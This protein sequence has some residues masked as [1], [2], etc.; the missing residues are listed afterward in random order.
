MLDEQLLQDAISGEDE[1]IVAVLQHYKSSLYRV[2]YSYLRSEQ[3]AL[4]ALQELSY[5]CFRYI[6]TVREPRYFGTWLTK[7]MINICHDMLR[8]RKNELIDCSYAESSYEQ[9]YDIE[10]LEMLDQLDEDARELIYLKYV[11]D[12]SNAVIAK[13]LNI[14]EGTVKSRLYYT[15]RK[16]RSL[17]GE[18]RM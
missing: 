6:H 12:Q 10:W 4:E 1:A 2:A 8:K 9:S 16:L 14:P 3:D 17:F 18:E 7:M 13:R 5:R 15:L 11:N